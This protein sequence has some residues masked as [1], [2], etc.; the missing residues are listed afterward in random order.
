MNFKKLAKYFKD[1]KYV[2]VPDALEAA[3]CKKMSNHLL[4]LVEDNKTTKDDQCPLSQSIYGDPV[5]DQ[6]LEDLKPTIE[7][8]TGLKLNPTYSYARKYAPGDELKPHTDRPACE[9]SATLTLGHDGKVWPIHVSKDAT[10][11]KDVGPIDLPVG[12]LMIYRGMEINH[13]REP[14]KEGK[15]QCQVFLHYVDVDGPHKDLKYDGREKLGMDAS[16][17]RDSERVN[18]EETFTVWSFGSLPQNKYLYVSKENILTTPLIDSIVSYGQGKL[19]DASVGL[20][21]EGVV[22]KSIRKVSHCWLPFDRFDWL[23]R[24]LEVE[25]KDQ[26]WYN[27]KFNLTHMEQIDY[28]EYHAGRDEID[29]EHGHGKYAKHIDGSINS[30]RKLSFSVLL[31]DPSEFEGGD[32]LIYESSTP[33]IVPKSKGQITFFPSNFIHEVTPVTKGVRRSMVSWIH[34]PHFT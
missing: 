26:N 13:W 21:S 29:P 19:F 2:K 25:I 4:K 32:L 28:L 18:Q 11:E 27:Y 15:W 14:Y 7:K 34:G 20:G 5:L 23:Y 33:H 17:K 3:T 6:L 16:T 9:I 8:A 1:N 24:L 10:T 30:N 31:S 22:D 12:S